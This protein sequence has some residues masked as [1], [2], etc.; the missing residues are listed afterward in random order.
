[1]QCKPKL[2]FLFDKAISSKASYKLKC[3]IIKSSKGMMEV[4]RSI[5]LDQALN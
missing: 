4:N 1:M 3:P 2:T 5:I